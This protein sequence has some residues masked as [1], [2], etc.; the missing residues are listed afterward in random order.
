[1]AKKIIIEGSV[2]RCGKT[3]YLRERIKHLRKM[4]KKIFVIEKNNKR[5][6]DDE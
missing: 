3:L 6:F 2:S 4:G 5:N 1:M